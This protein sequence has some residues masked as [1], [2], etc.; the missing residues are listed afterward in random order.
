MTA[1]EKF[2]T[3]EEYLFLYSTYL[4]EDWEIPLTVSSDSKLRALG[5]L[6]SK[7]ITGKTMDLIASLTDEKVV[8]KVEEST[9]EDFWKLYPT[10]DA[11]G[12][13]A[14]TRAI[15]KYS[16]KKQV[17][18]AYNE[19][20]SSSDPQ[21]IY[22]GLFNYIDTLKRRSLRENK[23]TYMV[24]PLRFLQENMWLDYLNDNPKETV[25]TY[26]TGIV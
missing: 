2:L 17:R 18:A 26:G 22:R 24:S 15:R 21:E 1:K 23:L 6:D 9:F 19:A 25:F 3:M 10:T 11:F 14:E 16:S 7:G 12:Q 8:P 13:W 4:C 20:L 5:Y